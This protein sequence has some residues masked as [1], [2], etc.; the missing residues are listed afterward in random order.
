MASSIVADLRLSP[1]AAEVVKNLPVDYETFMASLRLMATNVSNYDDIQAAGRLR[2]YREIRNCPT[3][4]VYLNNCGHRLSQS[5][6]EFLEEHLDTFE[7]LL[8]KWH[9]HNFVGHDWFSAGTLIGSQDGT[10]SGGYLLCPFIGFGTC[11]TPIIQNLRQAVQFHRRT[12]LDRVIKCFEEL[13]LGLY[14]HATPTKFNAGTVNPQMSSCFLVYIGDY[15]Y[16]I[17]FSGP[18]ETAMISRGNGGVGICVSFIRAAGSSIGCTGR[19]NGIVPFCRVFDKT[20]CA[21]DQGGGKRKGAATLFLDNV[22]PDVMDFISARDNFAS[23]DVRFTTANICMWMHDLFYRRAAKGEHWTLF[24]P[25]RAKT[26]YGKYGPE[27]DREYERLERLAKVREEAFNAASIYFKTIE[28]MYEENPDDVQ[29]QERYTQ[30]QKHMIQAEK[31]RILHKV[32]PAMSLSDHI[33]DV[34]GKSG[35]PYM[36]NADTINYKSNQKNLGPINQS[37]LCLEICEYTDPDTIASCNLASLNLSAFAR[38]PLQMEIFNDK[39]LSDRDLARALSVC[40][41]F[42]ALGSAIRSVVEN[43]ENVIDENKDPLDNDPGTIS[44]GKISRPNRENRP[45]GIGVSGLDDVFKIIDLPYM[46]RPAR[47]LNKM[48][49]ACMYFNAQIESV[50]LAL[51]RGE[52]PTFRTGSYQRFTGVSIGVDGKRVAQFKTEYGSPLSNGQFQFDLWAEEAEMLSQMGNL[53][54]KIYN[55]DDDRPIPPSWW[56]QDNTFLYKHNGEDEES[57]EIVIGESWNSLR[58]VIMEYGVRHSLL[59]ALMPTAT[60][61][62]M[63]CNSPST[64]SH[65]GNIYSRQVLKGNYT[66]VNRHLQ[67]DLEE[68]RLYTTEL[69]DFLSVSSGSLKHLATF[70]KDHSHLYPAITRDGEIIPS[71]AARIVH[72]QAKYLTMFEMSTKD[73]MN[74]ARD[75]GIYICQSQSFNIYSRDPTPAQLRAMHAYANALRLKTGMYYLRQA[76]TMEMNGLNLTASMTE[77]CSKFEDL[78]RIMTDVKKKEEEKRETSKLQ[79]DGPVCTREMIEAGCDSCVL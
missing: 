59:I 29:I 33:I 56:D 25:S 13:S 45:L 24:C 60:V 41:D 7:E 40:F 30:A 21:V 14:T 57:E 55:R 68:A 58:D 27:F 1:A 36:M 77:Y 20:I 8:K 43:L 19:S 15:L 42:K 70:V 38:A 11:E 26:L 31:E 49:F 22:H 17:S 79:I 50:N 4:R 74:A 54:T 16:S 5:V 78:R 48:I 9:K 3:L 63:M 61:A 73:M 34:Q 76:P 67:K 75:R 53:N 46:S 37:N 51:S 69:F 39:A 47:L 10:G 52:Y 18:G 44:R 28:K 64:E 2:V 71:V 12:G 65:Q 66:V 72:L 62:Q 6:Y 35:E 32:I 23:H